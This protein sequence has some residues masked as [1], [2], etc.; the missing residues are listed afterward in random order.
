MFGAKERETEDEL[1]KEAKGPIGF[2][3]QSKPLTQKGLER[4]TLK[5]A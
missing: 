1:R 2:H 3:S 5:E 4:T